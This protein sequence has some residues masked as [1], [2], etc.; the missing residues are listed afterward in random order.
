MPTARNA[1]SL[2]LESSSFCTDQVMVLSGGE[3]RSGGPEGALFRA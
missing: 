1:D 3:D 2:L